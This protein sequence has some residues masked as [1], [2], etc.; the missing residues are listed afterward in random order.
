VPSARLAT[1][2]SWSLALDNFRAFLPP[3][4]R[5]WVLV[6]ERT[7]HQRLAAELCG[8]LNVVA[9]FDLDT[10][11]PERVA[12]AADAHRGDESYGFIQL[13]TTDAWE[14]G[15]ADIAALMRFAAW[16]EQRVRFCFQ[17]S[18][19]NFPLLFSEGPDAFGRRGKGL[20]RRLSRER[21]VRLRSPG[22]TSATF[23]CGAPGWTLH[24]GSDPNDY[25]LPTGEIECV[26]ADA[27]GEIE[28]SGWIVGTLPFG[29]KYGR[30][31]KGALTLRF[32]HGRIDRVGGEAGGLIADLSLA[33]HRIPRLRTVSEL[34]VG[35]SH[36]VARAARDCA[37]GCLWHERHYGAH[38]GIGATLE[39]HGRATGHHLDFV[40]ANG[41]IEGA[42]GGELLRW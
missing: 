36:G 37:I 38:I 5:H 42:K 24:D 20:L 31:A 15:D 32:A 21:E 34:G 39:R 30:I 29:R 10:D 7:Y 28:F 17:I 33:F 11:L 22:D 13:A 18:D 2:D 27:E 6:F 35:L 16:P 19:G 14:L 26:P 23:L 4:V 40:L 9:L 12:T 25:V 41:S 3:S 1:G 8:A